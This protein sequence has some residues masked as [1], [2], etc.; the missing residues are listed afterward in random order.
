MTSP[1]MGIDLL[2]NRSDKKQYLHKCS[3]C[4]HYNKMTFGM[5]EDGGNLKIINPDGIDYV[6]REVEDGSLQYV[7]NKCG[8]P[9]DR[10]YNGVWVSENPSVK[11]TSGYSISQLNAVW[12]NA[13]QLYRKYLTAKTKQTFYNYVIGEPYTDLSLAITAE[14]IYNH[15]RTYLPQR[16]ENKGNYTHITIGVDWGNNHNIVVMGTNEQGYRD[17]INVFVVRD[18]SNN[19]QDTDRDIREVIERIRLYEPDLI[20]ADIGYNGNKVAKLKTAFGKRVYGVQVNPAK[21]NGAIE[22]KWS[23]NDQRVTIDKLTQNI[24]LTERIKEGRLGFWKEDDVEL[25]TI[26]EHA[27]NVIIR[28]TEDDDGNVEKEITR[29]G[30]D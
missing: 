7:C 9:L 16:L 14:D 18:S 22:G 13:D 25:Q 17:V 4:N 1:G 26:L 29:K 3:S 30:A 28:D 12:I 8:K 6:N 19:Q 23:D 21:S 24:I 15:R 10:W 11:S 2:Y 5:F 20:L 27:Q